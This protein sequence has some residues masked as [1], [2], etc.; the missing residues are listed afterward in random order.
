M[1]K[2]DKQP[3]MGGDKSPQLFVRSLKNGKPSWK[4]APAMR[5]RYEDLRLKA[6]RIEN[7]QDKEI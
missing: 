5:A 4:L 3:D 2:I 7:I 6:K 1:M